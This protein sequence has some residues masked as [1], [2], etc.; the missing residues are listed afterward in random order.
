MSFPVAVLDPDARAPA[1]ALA[2]RPVVGS[3]SDPDALARVTAGCD[4]VTIDIE[5][6]DVDALR[7]LEA[8][9]TVFYPQLSV[10]EIVQDK[11]LQKNHFAAHGI[12]VAEHRE[13]D[14]GDPGSL[15]ALGFPVV[16]KTRRAGYDGRGVAVLRSADDEPLPGPS[17]IERLVEIDREIAVLVARDPEGQ[18]VVYPPVE[19]V[20]DPRRTCSIP[21]L[22]AASLASPGGRGRQSSRS[23]RW[24]RSGRWG[25]SPSRCSSTPS[26]SSG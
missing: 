15:S 6:V 26:V 14:G 24:A 13:A 2:S 9:G 21:S 1:L 11:L 4:V 10:L 12:P 25:S 3:Y 22:L 17:L 7:A 5:H 8:E 18:H 16:Q 20:F 19:M 23:R